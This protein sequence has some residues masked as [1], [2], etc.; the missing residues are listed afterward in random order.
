MCRRWA[1][2][3]VA[4][5]P[6][7]WEDGAHDLGALCADAARR[8]TLAATGGQDARVRVWRV[9]PQGGG[10]VAA[11]VLVGH[12]AGVTALRWGARDTLA[13]ASLDRTARVWRRG[14]CLAVLRAHERYLT[15][16][17]LDPLLRYMLTGT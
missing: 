8:G 5:A 16:V 14:T 9:G 13:S 6:L 3:S 15:A 10:L 7:L 2:G 12:G 17:V 4:P 1:A 11:E